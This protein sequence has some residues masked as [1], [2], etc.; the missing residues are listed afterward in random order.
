MCWNCYITGPAKDG[1]NLKDEYFCK[2]NERCDY[3]KEIEKTPMGKII[4]N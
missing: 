4:N 1:N 3:C 2:F